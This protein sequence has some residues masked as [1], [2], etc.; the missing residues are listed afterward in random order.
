M[1]S[2]RTLRSTSA[3][4]DSASSS[5][6]GCSPSSATTPT[7]T[8]T[9]RPA[10]TTPAPARS[11]AQSGKKKV[12]LARYVHNDRLARRARPAGLHRPDGLT[13]RPR[14]LRPAHAPAA[15]ATTPPCASSPTDSSAS[16]TAASRPTPPTTKPPPG[17]RSMPTSLDVLTPWDVSHAAIERDHADERATDTSHAAILQRP[18]LYKVLLDVLLR[19]GATPSQVLRRE[20][21]FGAIADGTSINES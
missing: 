8:P 21:L 5:A 9:P 15:S 3:S 11:P 20:G 1:A 10:R 7:A 14:L 17:L 16:C 6:P 18:S 13:R 2:T 12:V 19:W 4:P